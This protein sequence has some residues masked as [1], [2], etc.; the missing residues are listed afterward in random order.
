MTKTFFKLASALVCAATIFVSCA[1]TPAN[2]AVQSVKLDESSILLYEGDTQSLKATVLPSG[3]TNTAVEW[4]SDNA[5]VATVSNSGMVTAVKAGEAKITV[6]TVDGGKTATCAVTVKAKIVSVQSV[7]IEPAS[8][9]MLLGEKKTLV[10]KVMPENASNPSVSWS[11]SDA[12]IASVSQSGEVEALKTGSVTITVTTADGGKTA[13]CAITID[14]AQYNITFETNGG[15]PI[16]PIVINKGEKVSKPADPTKSAGLDG[17]LYEGEVDPDNGSVSFGGWYT[18][19]DCTQAY[20]FNTV[21]TADLTLYAKWNS[22]GPKPIDLT[23]FATTI[24]EADAGKAEDPLWLSFQYLNSL[25]LTEVTKYTYVVAESNEYTITGILSNNNIE[26]TVV[27]KGEERILSHNMAAPIFRAEGG[28]IILSKN[29]TV[30][31]NFNSQYAIVLENDGLPTGGNVT[32]LAG[33]KITNCNSTSRAAAVY[34]N[35]GQS[36]FTLDGGEISNNVTTV[37]P[38]KAYGGAMC[39][40]WGKFI[41]NSGVVSGNETYCSSGTVTIGGAGAFPIM[42]RGNA[43]QKYGGEIKDNKAEYTDG[44]TG[45]EVGQQLVIGNHSRRADK[46]IYKVDANLGENDNLQMDDRNTNPL[47]IAV[48]KVE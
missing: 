41:I 26:V 19:P 10:A 23:E 8:A 37:P 30:S 28:H 40:N 32:M 16:D 48:Q 47:W 46:G 9:E 6:T 3:A 18:D 35:N 14:A 43:F 34:N 44:A 38:D 24:P 12:T 20:D 25:E 33:S 11:S 1:K 2:V 39:A 36:I 22:D 7:S 17:G 29:V 42:S 15:T 27:G 31:G 13:T 21:P 5:A 4:S 45:D